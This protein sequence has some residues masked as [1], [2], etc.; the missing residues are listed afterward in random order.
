MKLGERLLAA[1]G[2]AKPGF[3]LDIGSDH[4]FLPVYLILNGIITFAS[5]S[6]INAKPLEKARATAEK[7]NVSDKMDFIISDGFKNIKR[8]Y[9]TVCICGMGGELIADIIKGGMGKF[10]RL[11]LQPMTK[12]ESLRSFLWSSGFEIETE[13]YPFESGKPYAVMSARYTKNNTD[14]TR[15]DAFL[16]KIKPYDGDSYSAGY[17]RY[18]EKIYKSALKRYNGTAREEDLR[19]TEECR[20]ILGSHR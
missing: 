17:K 9:D 2:L 10:D 8:R 12:A 13:L 18:V 4:G 20:L 16:G 14:F 15:N 1:A 6:D 7:Y 3:L 11:I 19:L 5:V